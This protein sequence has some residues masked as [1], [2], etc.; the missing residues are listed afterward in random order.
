MIMATTM[1]T[2]APVARPP[3]SSL[4]MPILQ[5]WP[6]KSGGHSHLTSWL[7]MEHG[8][9]LKQGLGSHADTQIPDTSSGRLP[10]RHLLKKI[11]Q[12]HLGYANV[13]D[14]KYTPMKGKTFH[15][16]LLLA[17]CE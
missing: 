16:L 7:T 13:E 6:V 4:I 1:P 2:I 17:K 10:A 12:Y 9:L 14:T 8:T 15:T 5:Y 3:S 11:M